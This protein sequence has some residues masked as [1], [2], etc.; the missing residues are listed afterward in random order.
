MGFVFLVETGILAD[1]SS[2]LAMSPQF[3]LP[4]LDLA[5]D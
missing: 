3:R 5:Y 1:A 4:F 2:V